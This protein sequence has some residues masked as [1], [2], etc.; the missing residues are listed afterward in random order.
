[1]AT[2]YAGPRPRQGREPTPA[3]GPFEQRLDLR[4]RRVETFFEQEELAGGGHMQ[5]GTRPD[6]VDHAHRRA[7]GGGALDVD[8]LVAVENRDGRRLVDLPGEALEVRL[9]DLGQRKARKVRVAELEHAR[10]QGEV[11]AV[12]SDVAEPLECQQEAP[13]RGA[14]EPGRP[15]DLGER[16]TRSG[17]PQR[18]DHRQAASE[19]LN[20]LAIALGGN[21]QDVSSNTRWAIAKAELAAGTPA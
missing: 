18:A 16:Q 17:R 3:R 19:R 13:R 11:P 2:S 4:L 14:G 7:S 21:G 12:G 5:R 8:D 9:G 15:R 20:V 6:H 1:M 10:G